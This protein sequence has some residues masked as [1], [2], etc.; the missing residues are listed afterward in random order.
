M[1]RPEVNRRGVA[2]IAQIRRSATEFWSGGEGAAKRDSNG[3]ELREVFGLV[4]VRQ[5]CRIGS[6]ESS[7]K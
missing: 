7:T 4:D 1:L 6:N 3:L 5:R 2:S